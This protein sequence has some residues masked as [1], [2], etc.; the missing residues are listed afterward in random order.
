MSID[1]LR[2]AI[3]VVPLAAYVLLVGFINGRRRPFIT[4][5]GS[6]LFALGLALSGLVFVGPLELFRPEAAT[7]ELGNYIWPVLVLLYWLGC[8]LI[9]LLSRP[10]LVVYN[11]SMEQLHPALAA[12]A[13]RLDPE[14]RWAGNHLMMPT[15]GV[16]LH[17]DRFDLMRNVSLK[18]SGSQQ[19]IDGWR[20]LAHELRV[21]LAPLRV[22]RNPRA[23]G[24]LAVS[25]ALLVFSIVHMMAKPEQVMQAMR[26]VFAY[27]PEN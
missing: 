18:S 16:Q 5:G 2:L 21:S 19:N 3:A 25:L 4:S 26:Q 8:L 11:I 7:R 24:L 12:A 27:G 9:V 15:L 23:I 10:R 1:P 14:A 22:P 6:D 20:A 13:S 17:L